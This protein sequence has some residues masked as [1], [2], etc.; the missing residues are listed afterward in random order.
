MLNREEIEITVK[1]AIKDTVSAAVGEVDQDK[2][3]T[4]ASRMRLLEFVQWMTL[5]NQLFDNLL[6]L[7]K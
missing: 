5:L 1:T 3:E 4:L 7:L 6:I 2:N